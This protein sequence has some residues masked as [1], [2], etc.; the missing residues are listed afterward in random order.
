VREIGAPQTQQSRRLTDGFA[1]SPIRAVFLDG[2]RRVCRTGSEGVAFMS[3]TDAR[4]EQRKHNARAEA[5]KRF[6]GFHMRFNEV[7]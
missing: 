6:H 1:L 7:P 2:S 5:L 4:S 3:F